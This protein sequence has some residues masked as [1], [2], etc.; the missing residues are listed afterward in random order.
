[1]IKENKRVVEQRSAV[2]LVRKQKIKDDKADRKHK[3]QTYY[4][5]DKGNAKQN[6][7]KRYEVNKSYG[8]FKRVC[9]TIPP[10]LNK[11]L[12]NMPS[13]K[14]YIWR[15]VHLYGHKKPERNRPLCMFERRN[16]VQYIHEWTQHRYKVWVKETRESRKK[17]IT[18]EPRKKMV[19]EFNLL[20]YMKT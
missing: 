15:G 20:N 4:N 5:K 19:K 2:T 16:K 18:N 3:L 9:S 14:G 1:M 13:N 6:R 7:S 10:Y 8:Y 11:N 17:L 12:K